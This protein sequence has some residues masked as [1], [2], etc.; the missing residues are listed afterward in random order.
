[1][2]HIF[3]IDESLF[4]KGIDSYKENLKNICESMLINYEIIIS[5]SEEYTKAISRYYKDKLCT[6]YAVGNDKT[7]NTILNSI[8]GG[9]AFLGVIPIGKND[10]FKNLIESPNLVTTCNV[11]KINDIYALNIF[12]MGINNELT[13]YLD[14][15]KK[16]PLTNK[17]KYQ[18]A[19]MLAIKNHKSEQLIISIDDIKYYDYIDLIE[20]FNGKYSNELEN[21]WGSI[22]RNNAD[23]FLIADLT[24][25]ELANYMKKANSYNP[26]IR[27]ADKISIIGDKPIEASI[28]GRPIISDTFMIKTNADMIKVVRNDEILKRLKK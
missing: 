14:I 22:T 18:L 27:R 12:S 25:K 3:I 15:M 8:I 24:N 5:N 21:P 17:Q 20:I 23:I 4:N 11:M 10:F 28:D 26:E 6:I 1:M 13:K 2:K 16:Y 9:Q 19:L 7:T